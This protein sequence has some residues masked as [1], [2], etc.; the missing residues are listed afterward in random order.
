MRARLG[1]RSCR[2]RRDSTSTKGWVRSEHHA[3]CYRCSPRKWR[4]QS[5]ISLGR[6]RRALGG[7]RWTPP[8]SPS[9]ESRAGLSSLKFGFSEEDEKK[10]G[11]KN[12]KKQFR[13]SLRF[14]R[15]LGNACEL[16]WCEG[17]MSICCFNE[18]LLCL[19]ASRPCTDPLRSSQALRSLPEWVWM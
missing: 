6:G 7:Q 12:K 18:Q 9:Q 10:E 11:E 8:S 1:L 3:F 15:F 17:V 19:G 13:T 14:C 2:I 16:L 4:W 5:A